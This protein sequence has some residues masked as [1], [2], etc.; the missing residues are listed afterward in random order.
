M[1]A[2]TNQSI[3][4]AK[5]GRPFAGNANFCTY[6]GATASGLQETRSRDPYIGQIIDKVF[7]I[8]ARIGVGSMGVVYRARHTKLNQLVA[9]KVLQ[10]SLVTDEVVL[11]RF[12]R[13]AQAASS[14]DHPNTIR[15]FNYGQTPL[16]APYIAMEYLEGRD[17]SELV[18]EAFPL[19]IERVVEIVSQVASGL[20]LA[21]RTGI[22]HRDLK[23]ANIVLEERDGRDLVK[24][25]DFGIAKVQG[26]ESEGLTRDGLI[27]GTPA[28]MSPEQVS[29][30]NIGHSSD[31]FSLGAILYFLLTGQLPFNGNTAVD[32]ATAILLDAPTPPSRVRL[33]VHVPKQIEEVCLKAIEKDPAHRYPSAAVFRDNLQKAFSAAQLSGSLKSKSSRLASRD[34]KAVAISK[35]M[36]SATVVNM[37][38]FSK[39]PLKAETSSSFGMLMLGLGVLL[40]LLVGVIF[41][42]LVYDS[43]ENTQDSPE[44]KSEEPA[45]IP[46]EGMDPQQKAPSIPKQA[47]SPEDRA[48]EQDLHPPPAEAQEDFDIKP[49]SGA[50][51]SGAIQSQAGLVWPTPK[52]K[53]KDD[54]SARKKKARRLLSKAKKIH[55]SD[56]RQAIKMLL[57]A[58][59]LSPGNYRVWELLGESYLRIADRRSAAKAYQ[60]VLKYKP[61]HPRRALIEK[62]IEAGGLTP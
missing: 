59:K 8:E 17:L 46:E 49:A 2:A 33:E 34:A 37:E 42:F 31:L 13:E 44:P 36:E 50:I 6:C 25:L 12:K 10:Q 47:P 38:V 27:C 52:T 7:L 61:N 43:S 60:K 54:R 5:C 56:P 23:P 62:K 1:G 15:V 4:C 9:I 53:T 45:P 30:K 35:D 3:K 28:F 21:H 57:E 22:V 58:S 19:A 48:G 51:T 18:A 32:M 39:T 41:F 24:V 29:G 26:T 14:L 40:L 16:G 20:D 11:K 55:K